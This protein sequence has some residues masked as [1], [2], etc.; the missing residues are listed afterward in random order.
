MPSQTCVVAFCKNR[1]GIKHRFPKEQCVF[2]IW[3]SKCKNKKLNNLT[4]FETYEKYVVCDI[5]FEPKCKILGTKRLQKDA[6][7]TLFLPTGM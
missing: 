5:H 3:V 1:K 7:P 2:N 4:M 6:I